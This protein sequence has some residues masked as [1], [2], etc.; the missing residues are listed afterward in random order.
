M[1]YDPNRHHRRSIRL[2]GYDYSQA[3]AYFI[4]ICTQDRAC[5]F[6]KVVNGEMRLNDAGRMVLA[7]WN[8]LPERF[9]HVV[10]DAFVVMPNHVHGIV[11]I[12][13]P[14]TDDGAT[15]R[16][17]P[18]AVTIVGTGL[19]PVPNTGTMGA[20]PDAG[21]MGAVSNA[22]T[23][24]A[25][26]DAGTMGAAPDTGMMGAVPNAG[27]MG[28]APN[29]GTMGAAPDAGTMGAV[30]DAGTMGAVPDAGTMGAAPDAGTMG[31]V[32]DAGMMGAAPDAGTMGAVPNAGTM[33]AV[34]DD[35]MMGAAPDTGTMG[36]APDTGA[37]GAVPDAGTMGAVP[38]A[39]TMGA[40]PN[41]GTMGAVPNAGTMGAAPDAGATTRVAPTAATIVGTGLV[42]VPDDGATTRVAPTV[43]DIVAPTVG[44]IV[45]AFKSRVTVEYIRGVKTSGWPPFRGR[46][47][48][49]NYY[50]HIIRNE[51]ALNAIRQYIIENPRRWQMDRENEA[52]TAP[53]PLAQAIWN[54]LK[55]EEADHSPGGER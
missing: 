5:L 49:R 18:T 48:Q 9:P 51:R 31:A 38:N 45:G 40:V 32:P 3:G 37:M 50:E 22:G 8:M 41:A 6:G 4:T 10:L 42:P 13:N 55:Q 20:V 28:A 27:A 16:V 53:D 36:A 14:A 24:G 47:W 21:T 46:L 33:G 34:P 15:T 29:A 54:M 2:K 25:A 30:P 7:E 52:R 12:T 19:V 11:V 39:G 23:M 17:A 35:G 1:P 26:P 44:D 43:G